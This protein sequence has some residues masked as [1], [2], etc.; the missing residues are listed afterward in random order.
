MPQFKIDVWETR[1]YRMQYTVEAKTLDEAKELAESG[2]TEEEEEIQI[3]G[4]TNRQLVPEESQPYSKT[5]PSICA[6]GK[7]A[8]YNEKA[9]RYCGACD[10]CMPF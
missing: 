5:D 7:P 1:D 9:Q 2:E 8:A 6:C 10:D 3:I 4:V